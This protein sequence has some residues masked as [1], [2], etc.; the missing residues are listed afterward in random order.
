MTRSLPAL[1]VLSV[2]CAAPTQAQTTIDTGPTDRP[3][4]TLLYGVVPTVGQIWAGQTFTVPAVDYLLS[5]FSF[6]SFTSSPSPGFSIAPVGYLAAWSGSSL[7]GPIL[8]SATYASSQAGALQGTT[9][10]LWNVGGLGLTPGAQYAAFVSATTAYPGG[11]PFAAADYA[12]G[13]WIQGVSDG[14]VPT[15]WV[16]PGWVDWLESE[17]LVFRAEFASVSVPEPGTGLLMLTGLLGLGF[18]ARR[19]REG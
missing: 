13:D 2:L 10:Y 17:D 4:V 6:T 15:S 11:V 1:V 16:S 14:G 18:V 19:R 5:T 12:G 9:D 8:F 7:S 3:G